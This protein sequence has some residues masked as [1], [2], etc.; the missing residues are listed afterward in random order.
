[1]EILHN[2]DGRRVGIDADRMLTKSTVQTRTES[3]TAQTRTDSSTDPDRRAQGQTA[4]QAQ[5]LSDGHQHRH[6]LDFPLPFLWWALV[7]IHSLIDFVI[8]HLPGIIGEPHHVWLASAVVGHRGH[9]GDAQVSVNPEKVAL[10]H[11]RITRI[12]T[13]PQHMNTVSRHGDVV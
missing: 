9:P 5:G 7:V 6:V 4:A 2:A 1:M 12:F 13:A 8:Y 3:S 11:M 10:H